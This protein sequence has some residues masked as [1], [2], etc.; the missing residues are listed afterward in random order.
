MDEK[1]PSPAAEE[2]EATANETKTSLF[3]LF[4]LS[5]SSLQPIASAPQWLSN[6]SFT[7][8]ISVIHDAV[9]ASQINDETTHSPQ[10]EP[11]PDEEE[12]GPVDDNQARS[13]PYS[14]YEILESS[15]SERENKDRKKKK[16][17]RK[18]RK[19]DESSEK[20]GFDDFGSRKSRVRA[21]AGSETNTT[22]DYYF[23]SHGDRDNLAFGCIYRYTF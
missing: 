2:V 1:S 13:K 11:D 5:D 18:K 20:R 23:D 21:W 6:S 8:D 17:K 16:K 19:R 4:P 7:T 3:P 15:E 22:K 9:V 12:E 10:Q 14:S